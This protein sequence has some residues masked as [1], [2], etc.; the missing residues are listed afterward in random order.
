M[1]Y[2]ITATFTVEGTEQEVRDLIEQH[3]FNRACM[4]EAQL[5]DANGSGRALLG[6]FD[7]EEWEDEDTGENVPGSLMGGSL[8]EDRNIERRKQERARRGG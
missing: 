8:T 1:K 2:E 6:T 7:G 3:E 4:D 5:F